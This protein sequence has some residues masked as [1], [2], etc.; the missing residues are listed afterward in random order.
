MVVSNKTEKHPYITVSTQSFPLEDV[1]QTYLLV[2]HLFICAFLFVFIMKDIFVSP[3][4][5]MILSIYADPIMLHFVPEKV[6][7]QQNWN[8][9]FINQHS[10]D[11]KR[12][13]LTDCISQEGAC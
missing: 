6:I 11:V 5:Y 9:F 12:I 13:I 8:L 10:L 1:L 4:Y 2:R 7:F 3:L